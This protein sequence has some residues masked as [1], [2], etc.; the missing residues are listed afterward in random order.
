MAI[1]FNDIDIPTFVNVNSIV[2]SILPP[3]SQNTVKVN[4]RAGVL[5]FGNE[6]N[7]RII[8]V[9]ITIIANDQMDLKTKTRE[10]AEWLYYEEEKPL[11]IL[12][13]LDKYYMA[14][15]TQNTDLNEILHVGQGQL[16][17]VCTQPFA[18]GQEQIFN[19]NPSEPIA[20]PFNNTGGTDTYP[21]MKFEFIEDTTEFAIVTDEEFLIFG[22]PLDLEN[23]IAK[24]PNPLVLFDDMSSTIGWTSANKIDGGTIL[25]NF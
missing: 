23:E 1:R 20:Y 9:T 15:I 3:I 10:L 7:P 19:F 11:I 8:T 17:F 18:Y 4:G 2:N 16:S 25:G 21:K 12:D 5:D 13:E 22:K 14:K 24:D 6:I